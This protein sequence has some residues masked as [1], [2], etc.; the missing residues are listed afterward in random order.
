[1]TT[2][3]V[4]FRDLNVIRYRRDLYMTWDGLFASIGGIFGLCL[5]GSVLSLVEM[6]YFFTIRLALTI[7]RKLAGK[8]NER[9]IQKKQRKLAASSRIYSLTPILNSHWAHG[10]KKAIKAVW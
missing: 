5:G 1:M 4:Y 10:E 7:Y 8:A 3:V 2:L 6:A 9:Q